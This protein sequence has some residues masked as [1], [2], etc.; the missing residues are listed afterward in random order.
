MVIVGL[1]FSAFASLILALAE[2]KIKREAKALTA[3]KWRPHPEVVKLLYER[4]KY[5]LISVILLFIGFTL[6]LAG[7]I[8]L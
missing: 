4:R 8:M 5:A 3:E 1:I 6:Q 7:T 2:L